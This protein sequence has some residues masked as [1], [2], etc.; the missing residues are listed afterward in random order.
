[1]PRTA[2]TKCPKFHSWVQ[3]IVEQSASD[4]KELH[5]P[6]EAAK[7]NYSWPGESGVVSEQDSLEVHSHEYFSQSAHAVEPS[8]DTLDRILYEMENDYRPVVWVLPD[9]FDSFGRFKRVVLTRLD[10]QASP[11]YPY[12]REASTVGQWLGWDSFNVNEVRLMRLWYDVQAVIQD[13]WQH[14]L[15]VFIKMEPHK[16]KKVL[17]KRWRLIMSNSL[18]VTVLWHMLFDFMNDLEIEKAYE[19]PSQ[20]GIRMKGGNWRIFYESWKSAGL[21]CGL[22]K[23]SWDWTAPYWALKLDLRFRYRMGRGDH[24]E[25]WHGM[26]QL[27]YRH[28]FEEPYVLTSA[29][30]LYRQVVPGIMKSGCVNTISTNSH[31]QVMIHYA[32]CLHMGWPLRPTP[33]CCG[34]D[35]LQHEKH[36]L[37]VGIYNRFG[38]IIKEVSDTM[39]FVGHTF[40][41]NGPIPNYFQKHLKK[42]AYVAEENQATYLDQMARMYCHTGYF[43]FWNRVAIRL[44]KPLPHSRFNYQ[45]WYNFPTD[46]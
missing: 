2:Q 13:R 44:E 45:F 6:V 8:P 7:S 16:L 10:M 14:V 12:L 5:I 23:S 42:I 19:I 9:D 20:Q 37:D 28:M 25:R 29:G 31:M 34:D 46:D 41:D 27:L 39:E 38:A 35:T 32:V 1:M 18:P 26:A 4:S 15:K 36:T 3:E 21:S 40:T 30:L 33:V 43:E 11:G 17:S 22:D 24:M